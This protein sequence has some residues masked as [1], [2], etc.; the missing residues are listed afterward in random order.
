M[1][2][3]IIYNKQEYNKNDDDDDDDDGDDDY[4]GNND[5]NNEDDVDDDDGDGG[6]VGDDDDCDGNDKDNNNDNF[7]NHINVSLSLVL[8]LSLFLLLSLFFSVQNCLDEPLVRM[9][10][11]IFFLRLIASVMLHRI[12]SLRNK[13]FSLKEKRDP[14]TKLSR[15]TESPV[16]QGVAMW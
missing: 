3:A 16:T 2:W 13:T 10:S 4:D 15:H 12:Y 9:N 7:D 11:L 5:N 8:T 14:F 6:S 1:T